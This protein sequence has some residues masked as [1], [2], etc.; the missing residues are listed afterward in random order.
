MEEQG[1][2]AAVMLAAIFRAFCLRGCAVERRNQA[3][4]K[5]LFRIAFFT[6]R[7]AMIGVKYSIDSKLTKKVSFADALCRSTTNVLGI[8]TLWNG[9]HHAKG[10]DYCT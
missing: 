5:N 2:A 6:G 4:R 9:E 10:I 1:I 3:I 7:F 8:K